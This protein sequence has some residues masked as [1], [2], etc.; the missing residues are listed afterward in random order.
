MGDWMTY[1]ATLLNDSALLETNQ[2][3][4]RDGISLAGCKIKLEWEANVLFVHCKSF[5]E[6]EILDW[7]NLL[8]S[9]YPVPRISADNPNATLGGNVTFT[10]E[11]PSGISDYQIQWRKHLNIMFNTGRRLTLLSL[12]LEDDGRYSCQYTNRTSLDTYNYIEKTSD[13]IYLVCK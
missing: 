5:F 3:I 1:R 9:G 4:S 10:C 11:V 2:I 13:N 7:L 12:S 8:I 6:G